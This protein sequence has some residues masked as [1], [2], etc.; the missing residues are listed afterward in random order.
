MT[1]EIS[2]RQLLARLG[3]APAAGAMGLAA[4]QAHGLEEIQLAARLHGNDAADALTMPTHTYPSWAR[5]E[6][7]KDKVPKTKL[8]NLE[9]SRMIF[10]GNL[11][12]GWAHAR[13]LIYASDLIKAYHHRDKVFETLRLAEACGINTIL[14]SPTLCDVITDYWEHGGGKIQFISDLGGSG[15][16][17]E[18]IEYSIDHGAVAC[19]VHGGLADNLAARGDF[20]PIADALE[21]IRRAGQPAGIGAHA[22]ATVQ[23]CADR[24]II[25]D[26]WMKTLHHH[27]YWSARPDEPY[28][29]NNWCMEPEA[30][31]AFMKEREEPWLAF[32]VLAAGALRPEDGFRYAF[33]NGADFI[34]V[35]MYDFQVVEDVNILLDVLQSDL[36]RQR[37]WF[38]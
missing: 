8:G 36:D 6:D 9:V 30:T 12:G 37:A 22:Q 29:G 15:P 31:I 38:A 23:G 3:A 18:R 7:L 32:K 35:G 11:I 4:F 27:N 25:P 24:G 10:G 5:L 17:P 14:T 28:A 20:D 21:R 16:L 19:Y 13:D 26:F 1:S 34:C 33:E 2:R